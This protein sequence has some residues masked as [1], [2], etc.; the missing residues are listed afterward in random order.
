MRLR[1]GNRRGFVLPLILVL[2]L[3]LGISTAALFYLP[4]NMGR[5]A[6][7][8]AREMQEIYDAESSIVACL[9][10]F[11]QGYFGNLPEVNEMQLGPYKEICA[12]VGKMRNE[13]EKGICVL[14]V[15]RFRELSVNEWMSAAERY[16]R[17]LQSHIESFPK[18][19]S[20]SG[21]K[22]FFSLPSEHFLQVQE[23]DLLLDAEGQV[24]SANYEV[25]GNVTIKGSVAF[26]TLRVYSRG[27]ISVKG[28]VSVRHL[29]TSG[30]EIDV[31]S[32]EE[33][34]LGL[35]LPTSVPL[36]VI[37]CESAVRG[38]TVNRAMKLCKVE[39]GLELKVPLFINDG[40]VI[41]VRTDNGAYDGRA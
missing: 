31:V 27:H 28:R 39:T 17:E 9:A 41:L 32:F 20:V 30:T 10:G 14:G 13:P 2:F 5:M 29:E 25:D 16:R 35:A 21:N 18:L 24:R 1:V 15:E 23:G 7:K 38:D 26:D 11:P 19:K 8:N 33:E 12:P 36:K 37:E 3:C 40:D 34:I 22:R 6:K 4:G